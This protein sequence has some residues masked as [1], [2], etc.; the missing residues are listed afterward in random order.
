MRK[1]EK[2]VA[3]EGDTP[4]CSR[5]TEEGIKFESTEVKGKPRQG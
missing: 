1:I 2:I 4:G 3:G 5:R